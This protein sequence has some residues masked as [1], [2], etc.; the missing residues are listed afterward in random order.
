MRTLR[1]P[2]SG[3]CQEPTT[4]RWSQQ[5]LDAMAAITAWRQSNDRRFF[6]LD[7]HAGTGKTTMAAEIGRRQSGSVVYGALTGKAAAV[8]RAKGCASASTIDSLIYI[9]RLQISCA[10]DEPCKSP[11]CGERCCFARQ[12][13]IGRSL[14]K[15]SA[16]RDADFVIVDEVSMVGRQMGEDLLSFNKPV[17]VF[18]DTAQLPSIGDAGY[19]TSRKPDF[20]LTE[21][22]RQARG[23]PVIELATRVRQGWPLLLGG[24]GDSAVIDGITT[25]DMLS[26][27]QII[28]GTHRT[29]HRINK[30]IRQAL[31]YAGPVPQR[32]EKVLCL[33]NNRRLGLRNGTTWI[34]LDA[35]PV[36]DGF[37]AMT[38]ENDDGEQVE[39]FAPVE[40][41]NA[42]DA[43]GNDLPGEP[44]AFGYAITC[45]KAQGSQWDSVLVFDESF[46]FRA[47]GWRWLYTAVTR[48]VARVTVVS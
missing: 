48:A 42:P 31:G 2:R 40:G 33:K 47:D 28:V 45:H 10:A 37:I 34:V 3:S 22:H 12:R 25:K 18:G 16:V 14:N 19:F 8:M 26:F 36:G 32:G 13:F 5:Q 44:F 9:P 43:N 11:P 1:S 39:V 38:V 41:F 30:Q 46:V 27:D 15:D 17:I 24:Y 21:I 20:V 4:S 35:A 6:F 23:S 29:R 7:G